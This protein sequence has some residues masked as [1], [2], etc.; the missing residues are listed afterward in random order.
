MATV[1]IDSERLKELERDAGR[2]QFLRDE[3]NWGEDCGD[4]WGMLGE[5]HG[6]D[7]DRIVDERWS[8]L[9]DGHGFD[10]AM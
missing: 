9:D 6:P 1:T 8:R 10:N 3:D 5:S 2:Y 4:D 7:F